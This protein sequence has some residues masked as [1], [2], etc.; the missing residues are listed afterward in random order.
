MGAFYGVCF[1]EKLTI[2]IPRVLPSIYY[3]CCDLSQIL[4][5]YITATDCTIYIQTICICYPGLSDSYC[6]RYIHVIMTHP[7]LRRGTSKASWR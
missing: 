6:L 5:L 7:T 2:D 1:S 4:L 3:T